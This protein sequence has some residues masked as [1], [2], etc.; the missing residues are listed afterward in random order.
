MGDLSTLDDSQ[1]LP[2]NTPPMSFSGSL[3]FG[4]SN[5]VQSS[6]TAITGQELI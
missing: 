4:H 5:I 2:T 6:N 1:I 3:N